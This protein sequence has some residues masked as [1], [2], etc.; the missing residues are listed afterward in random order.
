VTDASVLALLARP[1]LL[2]PARLPLPTLD[3]F[4]QISDKAHV[5]SVAEAIGIRIPRQASAKQRADVARYVNEGRLTPPVVLK[6][7]RSVTR[8]GSGFTKHGVVHAADW[9]EVIRTSAALPESAFPLLIQERIVGPGIGVFLL[10]WAGRLLGAFA[11]ERLREKPPAGGVSVLA[12]SVPLDADLL[13]RSQALLAQFDWSGVAM[14]EY[15]RDS[16]TG[17]P[18]L[19]EINGRFW[20]SLQLA[21]DSGVD[22]PALLADAALGNAVVPVTRWRKGVRG[23]WFWGDADHFITRLR[24]S[25]RALNLPPDAPGRFATVWGF[26]GALLPPW[27]DQVIRLFDL[28][29]AWRELRDRMGAG[30][31]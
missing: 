6:P 2:H 28:A 25:A 14:I 31:A 22:F 19:M 1:Q 29:P 26:A 27:N 23:R 15:K 4:R 3:S 9:G 5:A 24:R 10:V 12:V 21:I 16:A 30:S 17:E 18:V 8:A 7:S 13:A 11:H 20:G